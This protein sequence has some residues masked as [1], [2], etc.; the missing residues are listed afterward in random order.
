MK[1]TFRLSMQWLHTWVGVSLGWILFLIF[2]N[3]TAAYFRQEITTWM[4]P[5]IGAASDPAKSVVGA[6]AFLSA[7]APD[8]ATWTISVPNE[9]NPVAEVTWRPRPEPGAPS[10]EGDE[11]D[12]VPPDRRATIDAKG[13]PLAARETE[14]G[15]YFYQFHFAFRYLPS[16]VS[17]TVIW[18]ASLALMVA[19]TTGLITHRRIFAEFFTLRLRSGARSW[20]DAHTMFAVL[21]LPFHLMI[22]YT[23]VTVLVFFLMP[24]AVFAHYSSPQTF[25]A[26]LGSRPHAAT[27]GAHSAPLVS[28]DSVLKKAETI[29][30]G[31]RAE[32]V[33]I[34]NPGNELATIQIERQTHAVVPRGVGHSLTFNG[35]TGELV[36]TSPSLGAAASAASAVFNLHQAHF[37][38]LTLRWLLFLCGVAGTAM[39]AT[40]LILWTAKRRRN[41]LNSDY[42]RRG[43]QLVETLNMA[44]IA[45]Y[46]AMAAA[47]FLANRLLPLSISSRAN[48]EIL[49]AFG[50]WGGLLLWSAVR[51]KRNAW[52]EVLSVAALLF[53]ALP[54]VNAA[55]T[56]R[57]TLGSLLGGDALYVAFD[58]VALSLGL[59]FAA[60]AFWLRRAR[61]A[62]APTTRT[63]E[64]RAGDSATSASAA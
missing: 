61:S 58:A 59:I 57:G 43:F 19:L 31:G 18:L 3:G 17:M 35:I 38:P 7:K 28:I 63:G 48:V 47:Y 34:H 12:Q 55:T 20:R 5:E 50:C 46:P 41:L 10:T 21:V 6:V 32:T 30:N 56:S 62:D 1:G 64:S 4:K 24:W 52:V 42:S 2:F 13:L 8:A 54:F 22:T 40:G 16:S 15:E 51:P 14:G 26:A 45:G 33:R 39:V 11:D 9:R 29:W 44:V 53:L 37:A 25:Y 36:Q 60:A 27:L 49:C 23:G